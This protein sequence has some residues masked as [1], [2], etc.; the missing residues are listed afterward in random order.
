MTPRRMVRLYS[1]QLDRASSDITIC[2]IS[3][4]SLALSP[5]FAGDGCWPRIASAGD[6]P[7][8]EHQAGRGGR[9]PGN[10][11]EPSCVRK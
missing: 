3:A 4:A 6:H 2:R 9:R 5:R 1:D 8:P 7:L 11:R 10:S